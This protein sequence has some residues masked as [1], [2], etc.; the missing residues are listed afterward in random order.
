MER[1]TERMT[2]AAAA[3]TTE[4]AAKGT[5]E[6]PDG[7]VNVAI[8]GVG[9][10]GSAHARA[11]GSGRIAGMRLGALCDID[12]RKRETL[13]GLYP[14]VPVFASAEEL[15]A[16]V[17]AGKLSV[18]AV[19]IATPHRFHAA[20]GMQAVEAGLHVLSEKPADVELKKAV[21]LARTASASG[22]LYGI[23]FNQRT[24]P[25]YARAREIIKSGELGAFK[26]SSWVITNW[27]R[28]Q[29]YYDSGDWRATWNGEGG[30]VLLNQAPHNIDLWLWMLGM[31]ESVLAFCHEGKY[32]RIDVED[33]ATIY[34]EFPGGGTGVFVTSTGEAPGLNR[35]EMAFENGRLIIENGVLSVLRLGVPERR[36]CF[37]CQD[38]Y[39]L[40]PLSEER[41][42]ARETRDG[43]ELILEDFASAVTN[44]TELLSPGSAG[45]NELAFSNACYLSSWTG[46]R[47][48]LPLS[49]NDCRRFSSI[50][51]EKRN[52]EAK[53]NCPGKDPK[54]PAN[55]AYSERW[56]TR[57]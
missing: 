27:Y 2:D 10:I 30:G 25:V 21:E 39:A 57:W 11:T 33:E 6:R 31:P 36:F 4:Q 54:D 15:F 20:I 26:R 23:M 14:G 19:I 55:A 49:D 56:K 46:E 43:H 41:F 52:S 12:P 50:L 5:T 37:E 8:I 17:N 1:E 24:D 29:A 13:S 28:T 40:P 22:K 3:G 42:S 32:H 53:R 47:V 51:E 9:N 35:L 45:V 44:G 38:C 48:I 18:D 7:L 16:A 34:A